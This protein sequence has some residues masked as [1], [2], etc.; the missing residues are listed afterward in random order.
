MKR[1]VNAYLAIF[2]ITIVGAMASLAI[3]RVATDPQLVDSYAALLG[4]HADL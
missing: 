2:A 1:T 3:V 4:P